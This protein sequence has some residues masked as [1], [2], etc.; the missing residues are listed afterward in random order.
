[1][2]VI[3][4]GVIADSAGRPAS[5]RIEFTQAQR[6]DTGEMLVTQTVAIA[7]VVGG[8][9]TGLGGGAFELPS[10]PEGTAVQVREVLGG[11]TFQWWTKV[12]AEGPVEY[13]SLPIVVSS[14]VPASVFGPP[15]WV[16]ALTQA[17]A[18]TQT[19]IVA[20][21]EV[22]DSLGGLAGI[23]ARLEEAE[24]HATDSASSAAAA[25]GSKDAA[26]LE[27]D[28]AEAAADSVDMAAIDARLD[29]MDTSIEG[30][31]DFP[32]T[33]SHVPVRGG[34]GSQTSVAFSQSPTAGTIAQRSAGG[35]IKGAEPVASSDLATKLY[36]DEHQSSIDPE[37]VQ[38]QIDATVPPI[39]YDVIGADDTPYQAAS[40]A[41][42]LAAQG[43]ELLSARQN[44]DGAFRIM[45]QAGYEAL[46][47]RPDGT[48][49][50]GDAAGGSVGDV[51]SVILVVLA[52]QSNAEGRGQPIGEGL[53]FENRRVMMA[54][55]SGTAVSHL[56]TA[57]VPLSSQYNPNGYSFGTKVGELLSAASPNAEIVILNAAVGGS[58]LVAAPAPGSWAVG[59]SGPNPSLTPIATAAIS[60]TRDL[61]DARRPGV[62]VSSVIFWLQGEADPDTT[63]TNYSTALTAVVGALRTAL[64]ASSAPFV[65]GAIVPEY[66]VG[67][68]VGTRR[69]VIKVPSVLERAAYVP[70]V[71]NGGGSQSVS[72]TI[73][74]TRQA[75]EVLGVRMLEGYKRAIASTSASVPLK[76]LEVRA[77]KQG[78]GVAVSWSLPMCRYTAFVVQYS[79]AGGAWATVTRA[80][81]MDV[82]EVIPSV[83]GEIQI[84]VAT[85]NG[86]QTSEYTTPIT[87]IGA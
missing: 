23:Q 29:G 38:A 78:G 77:S 71:E 73:H 63:E 5:G 79:V 21:T 46:V 54:E 36:V 58:G 68:H 14:N 37:E 9:L 72:D 82:Q 64:G 75:Q 26:A 56:S 62:P 45:D 34:D 70:G 39:V 85:V 7:Q 2:S 24:Q 44:T 15:P 49:V 32:S 84:R 20:G 67:T 60:R 40:A 74:Y 35:Q 41:V 52:G 42:A 6:L 59:Y 47:V 4:T 11:R 55:W 69:A 66:G 33:N 53:D 12:P 87:A 48:T 10:N 30:K 18:D 13:R 31:A 8:R 1:M 50:I 16:A 65:A 61:I 25:S 76:P 57:E 81:P 51:G 43:R 19:A 83:S 86:A 80:V 3:I 28:R 27:A 22:A 17:A